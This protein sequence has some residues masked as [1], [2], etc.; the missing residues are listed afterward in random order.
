MS[1]VSEIND[2]RDQTATARLECGLFDDIIE[3]LMKPFMILNSINI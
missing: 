1:S 2:Q 3:Y